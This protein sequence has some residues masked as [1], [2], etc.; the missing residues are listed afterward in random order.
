M[1]GRAAPPP[2]QLTSWQ[3]TNCPYSNNGLRGTGKSPTFPRTPTRGFHTSSNMGDYYGGG[4]QQGGYGG[5]GQQGGGWG[6]GGGCRAISCAPLK[7]GYNSPQNKHLHPNSQVS[8]AA[9]LAFT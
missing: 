2:V 8:T 5:G 7:L 1:G 4:G 3:L 6:G 9:A